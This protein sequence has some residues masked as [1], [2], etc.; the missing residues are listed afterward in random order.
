MTASI[1]SLRE[2][3]AHAIQ[4]DDFDLHAQFV[5]ELVAN[6]D[7]AVVDEHYRWL[8]NQHNRDLYLRLRLAMIKRGKAVVPFLVDMLGHEARLPMLRDL[9]HMLGRLRAPAALDMARR[10]IVSIDSD[11][12]H[13]AC[14]VIGWMG[15]ASDVHRLRQVLL[16]DSDE[17]VRR[18]AAT[19]HS[20]LGDRRSELVEQLL[21]N[22]RAAIVSEQSEDVLKWIVVTTQYLTKTKFGLRENLDD[23]DVEGDLHASLLRCRKFLGLL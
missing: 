22:M 3:Y 6:R 19:S 16:S 20:Q 9:L 13:R 18:T 21:D 10:E 5:R 1:E 23:S 11:M 2:M 4:T 15:D 7:P 17:Y 14:Y 12:R 8:E